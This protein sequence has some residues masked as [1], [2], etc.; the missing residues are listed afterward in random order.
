MCVG[1]NCCAVAHKDGREIRDERLE[2]RFIFE[3]FAVNKGIH[4]R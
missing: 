1:N 4:V 2:S 3:R